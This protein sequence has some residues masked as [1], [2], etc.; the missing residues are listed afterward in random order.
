MSRL[1][2]VMMVL[3]AC[4]GFV[5][6]ALWHRRVLHYRSSLSEP[7]SLLRR[8]GQLKGGKQNGGHVHMLCSKKGRQLGNMRDQV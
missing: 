4:L 7:L 1:G 8:L 6:G 3:T 2:L 5:S